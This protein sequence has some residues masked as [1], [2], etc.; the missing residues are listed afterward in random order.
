MTQRQFDTINPV[1]YRADKE[2]AKLNAE[3]RARKIK[4]RT[5]SICKRS[6]REQERM[7]FFTEFNFSNIETSGASPL[8]LWE[9]SPATDEMDQGEILWKRKMRCN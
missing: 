4:K 8:V 3:N 2:Q 5:D 9:W 7:E 6:E 1:D